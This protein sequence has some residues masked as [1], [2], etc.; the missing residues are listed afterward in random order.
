VIPSTFEGHATVTV[1]YWDKEGNPLGYIQDI[2]NVAVFVARP[3]LVTFNDGSRIAESN[4]F[5]L[6]VYTNPAIGL[7]E[8]H[9][10]FNV[11]TFAVSTNPEMPGVH[12]YWDL[13]MDNGSISGLLS[14]RTTGGVITD[15]D[16]ATNIVEAWGG[17]LVYY[18]LLERL[19]NQGATLTGHADGQTI[20]FSIDGSLLVDP[21]SADQFSRITFVIDVNA[22]RS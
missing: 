18:Q 17:G 3:G 19:I 6:E 12:Q 10:L 5:S 20:E 8:D 14:S 4:P 1:N 9:G 16:R 13:E 21:G 11:D 7:A 22:S 2:R 15:F